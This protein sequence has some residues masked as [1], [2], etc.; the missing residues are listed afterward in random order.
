MAMWAAGGEGRVAP[1]VRLEEAHGVKGG[2]LGSRCSA[3]PRAAAAPSRTQPPS[4]ERHSAAIDSS[5]ARHAHAAVSTA[6][7]WIS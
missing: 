1:L 2:S 6:R 3:M 5:S 7:S 4:S